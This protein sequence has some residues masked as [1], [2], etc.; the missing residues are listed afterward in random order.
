[1]SRMVGSMDGQVQEYPEHRLKKHPGQIRNHPERIQKDWI[2]KCLEW[3]R[4]EK[5]PER[6]F[7]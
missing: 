4:M 6:G 7:P 5:C 3:I 2:Q 1:M